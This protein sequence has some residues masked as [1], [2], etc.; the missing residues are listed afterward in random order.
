MAPLPLFSHPLSPAI[1]TTLLSPHARS[2]KEAVSNC[3]NSLHTKFKEAAASN[4][5]TGGGGDGSALAGDGTD[6]V[7]SAAAAASAGGDG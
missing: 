2:I 4:V 6:P 5:A 3:L 1:L 7:Y